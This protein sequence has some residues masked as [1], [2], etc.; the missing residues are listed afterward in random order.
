MSNAFYDSTGCG[1]RRALAL[2]GSLLATCA[3]CAQS[4]VVVGDTGFSRDCF[5]RAEL[6]V[7][8]NAADSSDVEVCSKALEDMNLT[9]A[10][11]A[12]TLVNRGILQLASGEP[13]AARASYNKALALVDDQ[14]ET[15]INIANMYVLQKRYQQ[16]VEIYTKGIELMQRRRHVAFLNRGLAYEYLENYAAARADY[17]HALELAPDWVRAKKMLARVTLK[18]RGV[19]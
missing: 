4:A 12:A 16:A 10:D 7:T 18:Q 9:L 11:R 19:E 15:H 8:F 14:G 13:E 1:I 5:S 2:V 17:A 6:A 3:V